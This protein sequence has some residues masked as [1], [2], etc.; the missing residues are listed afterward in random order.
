MFELDYDAAEILDAEDLAECGIGEAYA[1]LAPRLRAYGVEPAPLQE[2]IDSDAPAYAV[3][4][5]GRE[6][7]IFSPDT[8]DD[9]GQ[10]WGRAT[11]ALFEIVNA[12]LSGV[13]HRFYAING[14]NELGG[15]FL[16][17]AE[18]EAARRSLPQRT[19]WPYLPEPTHP[20]YGQHHS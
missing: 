1:S 6:W 4:C 8:E 13:E 11:C 20:W 14:G 18:V 15:I 5:L 3:R 17:P 19:D 7:V 16:T 9:E 10:S 2:V 12:Q